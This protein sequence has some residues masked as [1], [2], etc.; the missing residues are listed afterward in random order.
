MAFCAKLTEGERRAGRLTKDQKYTL[1]TEAQWEYACR[2]GTTTAYHAGDSEGTLGKAGWYMGNADRK[3][4]VVGQ[5]QSNKWGLYDMHGNVWEWCSDWYGD[6]PAGAVTDPTGSRDGASRVLRGSSWSYNP[7]NCRAAYR[8]RS[9]PDS[10][11][12]NYG[13]RVVLVG[14]SSQDP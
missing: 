6:Y 7:A 10:R 4:H 13:F 9:S 8:I 5:K 12:Y 11:N 14:F 1:P 2:A 3:T